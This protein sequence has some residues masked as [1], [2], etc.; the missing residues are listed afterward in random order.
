MTDFQFSHEIKLYYNNKAFAVAHPTERT[1]ALCFQIELK[2]RSVAFN[3]R[4]ENWSTL[5]KT[6]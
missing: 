6:L 3:E 5:R 2:F 4:E 1:F